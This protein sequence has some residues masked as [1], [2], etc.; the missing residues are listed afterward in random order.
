[1]GLEGK[2]MLM[3]AALPNALKPLSSLFWRLDWWWTFLP[4]DLSFLTQV[5]W[6]SHSALS[7]SVK[8][9]VQKVKGRITYKVTDDA[10]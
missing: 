10:L 1:M 6:D 3:L 4:M 2:M 9:T 7:Y 5:A 8:N